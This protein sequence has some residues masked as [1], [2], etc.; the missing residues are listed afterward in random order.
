[1]K[2]NPKY[3][4][5]HKILSPNGESSGDCKSTSKIKNDKEAWQAF[6]TGDEAAFSYIYNKYI[7]DL[8][9]YG[10]HIIPDRELVKDSVQ[11]VFIE[12]SRWRKRLSDVDSIKAYL[13]VSLRREIMRKLKQ[14][15]K[16]AANIY[17]DYNDS[18]QIEISPELK[19][20]NNQ[21]VEERAKKLEA[22]INE[23]SQRQRQAVLYYYY[24]GLS[25]QE[26]AQLL[27]LK[28]TKSAR[29][30]LYR[31]IASLRNRLKSKKPLVEKILFLLFALLIT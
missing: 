10:C 30:L 26:I 22:I 25:Y 29:K 8:Y 21:L 3:N 11:D 18:F 20:I 17:M 5:Q 24:E 15:K 23:L 31:A 1:M 27:E 12:L 7:D 4:V 19:L 14:D 2:A 9:N 6:K 13:Y 16:Y 28:K